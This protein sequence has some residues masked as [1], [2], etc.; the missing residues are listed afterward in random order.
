M[1]PAVVARWPDRAGAQ[2][3]AGTPPAGAGGSPG[4][5]WPCRR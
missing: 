4:R 5:S 2:R 3:A 1:F